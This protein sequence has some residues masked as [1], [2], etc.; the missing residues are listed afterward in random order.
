MKKLVIAAFV[1]ALMATVASAVSFPVTGSNLIGNRSTP[2]SD[3]IVG[4]GNWSSS[5]KGTGLELSWNISEATGGLWTY[6]YTFTE[7]CG[8]ALPD[9]VCHMLL[10][11]SSSVTASNYCQV[12]DYF[13]GADCTISAPQTYTCSSSNPGLGSNSIYAVELSAPC[14]SDVFTF[15]CTHSPMWGS[16]YAQDG[17]CSTYAWNSGIGT[18]P[19]V[20]TPPFTSWIPVPD[21]TVTSGPGGV[22]EPAT[23]TLLGLGLVGALARRKV[24]RA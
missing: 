24:A 1:V 20:N 16:F 13:N 6:T 19:T 18:Y 21:T 15:Q 22:P 3:G 14:T 5:G 17:S 11:V 4:N 2:T 23:L 7:A 12:F 10:E 8:K 9:Q